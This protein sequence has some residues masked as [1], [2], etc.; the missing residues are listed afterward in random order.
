QAT[1]RTIHSLPTRR[2]S[3]LSVEPSEPAV[4]GCVDQSGGTVTE[5]TP[6]PDMLAPTPPMGWNSW[7]YFKSDIS[8]AMLRQI[9]DA[10][11]SS[12]MRD[13][14]YT[15]VNIDDTWMKAGRESGRLTPDASKFPNGMAALADYVHSLGL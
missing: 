13:A 7:N 15:Y 3:D 8:D 2:S 1:P 6:D 14:G 11:V 12:G 9:A 5:L 10:M 4:D